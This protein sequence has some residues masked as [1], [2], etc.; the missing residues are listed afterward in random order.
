MKNDELKCGSKRFWNVLRWYPCSLEGRLED[1]V[2][3]SKNIR[4]HMMDWVR[5]L[6]KLF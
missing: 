5:I 2:K 1:T 6:L 3:V 4:T